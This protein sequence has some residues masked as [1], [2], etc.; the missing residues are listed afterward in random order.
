MAR[1]CIVF[2]LLLCGLTIGVLVIAPIKNPAYFI[3][4]MLGIPILFCGVVA[5]NPHRLAAFLRIAA[6]I[7]AFGG[8][9][10]AMRV[11][12]CCVRLSQDHGVNMMAL[13]LVSAMTIGCLLFALVCML[14]V[15]RMRRRRLVG[16]R[17]AAKAPGGEPT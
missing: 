15:V 9:V 17:I 12:A 8:F 2:G 16:G 10:G 4:M 13:R 14:S 6:A 1:V 7:A 3:P 5:L 11:G